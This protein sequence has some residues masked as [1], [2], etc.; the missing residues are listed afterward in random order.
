MPRIVNGQII[1]D[2]HNHKIDIRGEQR[3]CSPGGHGSSSS[4]QCCGCDW[5]KAGQLVWDVIA[6]RTPFCGV[7]VPVAPLIVG[8]ILL[9]VFTAPGIGVGV[10]GVL[11]IIALFSKAFADSRER[12]N[13]NA[14]SNQQSGRM[15]TLRDLPPPPRPGGG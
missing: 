13:Y 14:V 3:S 1:P 11:L 5:G 7:K 4:C 10:A 6:Y 15:R 12:A 8:C 2:G 9:G